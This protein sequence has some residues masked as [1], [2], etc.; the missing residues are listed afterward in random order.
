MSI[1]C[2]KEMAHYGNRWQGV[3]CFSVDESV[4]DAAKGCRWRNGARRRAAGQVWN[5][6]R[7]YARYMY[8]HVCMRLWHDVMCSCMKKKKVARTKRYIYESE[9]ENFFPLFFY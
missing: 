7:D 1:G 9:D 4:E 6:C 2:A 8:V 3:L 5:Q